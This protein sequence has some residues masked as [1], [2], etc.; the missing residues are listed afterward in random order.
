MDRVSEKMRIGVRM[1]VRMRGK[2]RYI[3]DIFFFSIP[4]LSSTRR[5]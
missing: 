4:L 5:A 1:R 2:I 3:C